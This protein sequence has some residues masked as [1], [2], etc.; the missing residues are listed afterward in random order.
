MTPTRPDS[1]TR[2]LRRLVVPLCTAVF[3]PAC[4]RES[5]EKSTTSAAVTVTVEEAKT[6]TLEATIETTGVVA[7]AP[8][9][10]LT[11]SAPQSARIAEI[12]KAEGDAVKA[13]DLLV[14]FD[15]PTLASEVAAKQAEVAQ[16]TA[17][18]DTARAAV[19]R[20][21][22]LVERGVAA[23]RELDDAKRDLNEAEAAM[24]QAE[25]GVTA[26]TALAARAVVRAPFAGV[27]A[28]RWHNPGDFV[29]PGAAD[30]VLR[31]ID[32][33]RL[34]V[35]A[36]V[37]I[38]DLSRI[39]VGHRARVVGPGG[40]EDG[41]PATVATRAAQVDPDRPTGDVRLTMASIK[42]P[43]GA[44]VQVSI[45]AESRSK[46]VTVATSAVVHDGDD[47]FV[48]T[49]G[50][51]GKAHRQAVTTGLA[52]GGRTEIKSGVRGGDPVIIHGQ[53]GLP[54]GAAITVSK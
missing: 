49:A 53:D 21:T 33:A 30:P 44:P 41:Q 2:F 35:I 54:D 17:R 7:P 48:F 3:L 26:A 27:V 23:Q 36:S 5:V 46:V 19:T 10:E 31:V 8:G 16:A 32:P 13:G 52:A 50:A 24:K 11:I 37:P 25:S 14:R 15:I 28:K 42:W 51:D 47:T 39:S 45:V 18:R 34:L 12:A 40:G 29:E 22:G 38:A 1:F 20:L 9:A 43:A 6:E 4:G